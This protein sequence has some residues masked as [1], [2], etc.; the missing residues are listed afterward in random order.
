MNGLKVQQGKKLACDL[1]HIFIGM[2]RKEAF[3]LVK[4]IRP[5]SFTLYSTVDPKA[6][7]KQDRAYD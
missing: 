6:S 5:C 2:E 1:L 3:G 4:I 7:R